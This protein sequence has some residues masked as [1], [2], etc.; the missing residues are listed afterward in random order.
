MLTC[1]SQV[2]TRQL[3]WID[4]AYNL[5]RGPCKGAVELRR[6][7]GKVAGQELLPTLVLDYPSV[8]DL[9]T[10]LATLAPTSGKELMLPDAGMVTKTNTPPSASLKLSW[11]N[12]T[13]GPSL[14]LHIDSGAA[15]YRARDALISI[16]NSRSCLGVS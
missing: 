14:A 16:D 12:A 6:D 3:I 9:A 5:S 7:L 1:I 4:F 15:A 8:S 13:M 11:T 10:H 2:S